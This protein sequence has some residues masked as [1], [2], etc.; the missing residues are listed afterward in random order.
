M[1]LLEVI[2]V[3]DVGVVKEENEGC[4][5]LLL[6]SVGGFDGAGEVIFVPK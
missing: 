5:G 6:G 3:L 4:R 2:G 1:G